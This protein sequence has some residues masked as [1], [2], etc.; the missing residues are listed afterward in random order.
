MKFELKHAWASFLQLFK[1][2]FWY[3][4]LIA[5]AF[6]VLP[7]VGH[8]LQE[9]YEALNAVARMAA[10]AGFFLSVAI[11]HVI[12]KRDRLRQESVQD[13]RKVFEPGQP[14]PPFDY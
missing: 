6:L 13:S 7:G 5:V 9:Q 2:M 11:W 8:F 4:A 10:V 14:S 12:A 1:F 3:A